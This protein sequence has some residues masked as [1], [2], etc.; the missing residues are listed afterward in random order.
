MTI[1]KLKKEEF[2]SFLD[3]EI[4]HYLARQQVLGWNLWAIIGAISGCVWLLFSVVRENI[5]RIDTAN[6]A[7]FLLILV[8]LGD[9]GRALLN[10]LNA[11]EAL[12]TKPNRYKTG[13]SYFGKD[14]VT[15]LLGLLEYSL[16]IWLICSCGLSNEL[17]PFK[18]V[19]C[20]YFG[21]NL[22]LFV[23]VFVFSFTHFVFP[24]DFVP[25]S[26][27]WVVVASKI[28]LTAMPMVVL[29][30]LVKSVWGTLGMQFVDEMR[31]SLLLYAIL[32]LFKK[33]PRQNSNTE[34]LEFFM[35]VRRDVLLSRR[36]LEETYREVE[37]LLLGEKL[38]D[39]LREDLLRVL[40][41]LSRFSYEYNEINNTYN[42]FN[43]IL[44]KGPEDV[45]EAELQ[46]LK[47]SVPV[48]ERLDNVD[49][50]VE[51]FKIAKEKYLRKAFWLR[52]M[53]SENDRELEEIES[54]FNEARNVFGGKI[55]E[56]RRQQAEIF[57]N[58]KKWAADV[59]DTTDA[60]LQDKVRKIMAL[61]EKLYLSPEAKGGGEP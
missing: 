32:Y 55:T 1:S 35:E 40:G 46:E 2:I 3:V 60:P 8:L 57:P 42:A 29:Y 21:F 43:A 44:A 23:S 6:I 16:W 4:Q 12:N 52:N 61:Y 56:V 20:A 54:K 17:I 14:R 22:F 5:L 7:I 34:L 39:V 11:R 9:I 26:S 30:G 36:R 18:L 33:I 37:I 47:S 48:H 50:E 49:A 10:V 59:I 24:I 15:I 19:G 28:V 41:Y 51:L 25:P 13:K 53:T 38:S 27:K 45:T 31:I 58:L